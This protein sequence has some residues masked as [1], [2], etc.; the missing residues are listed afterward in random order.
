MLQILKPG[1]FAIAIAA[2][3]ALSGCG[4]SSAPSGDADVSGPVE[5]TITFQTMQLSPTFDEYINGVIDAFEREHPGAEVE[6]VD[7]PSDQAARKV[8]ADSAAGSLP[9]VMDLDTATLAPLGRDGRVLDMAEHGERLRE[10]YVPSAWSSFDYGAT[11]VAALPWYLNSPVLIVNGDIVE[12]AGSPAPPTSY[13]DLLDAA[14]QITRTTGEAG[15]Q[16]TSI[17]FPNYLLSLGVPLVNE[18]STEAIVNTPEAVA[19]LERLAELHDL[20]AIPADSV[21]AAQ[22]SEIDTFSQGDIA[23]LETGPSRLAII[24]ENAPAIFED[25]DIAP[26]LGAADGT[27]WVVAHGIAVSATS[28]NAATALAFA[29]FMT[30]PENQLTLAQQSAVFPS[31]TVSLEDPFFA[32]EPTGPAT[33]A[34]GIVARSLFEGGTMAKPPAVDA[35]YA[36]LLWSSVQTAITGETDAEEALAA[37]EAQLTELLQGRAQ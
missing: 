9:D 27:T 2:A 17:G 23:Y 4:L 16:P 11:E 7:I 29:E 6:W 12:A 21:T 31:T 22:R 1:T 33:E 25:I 34:R 5:G 24:E 35:E 14:E 32:A 37:A 20:G 13:T 10:L 19:F 18:S 30:S 26:P 28:E 15:F 3:V 8:A 36:S